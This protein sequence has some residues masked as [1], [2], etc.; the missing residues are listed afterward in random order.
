[1]KYLFCF[2]LSF[3]LFAQ[4]RENVAR[5]LS[6][7]KAPEYVFKACAFTDLSWRLAFE[8]IAETRNL[9]D[10]NCVLTAMDQYE[11]TK[12]QREAVET[13]RKNAR[14]YLQ[15]FNCETLAGFQKAICLQ[16]K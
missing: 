2:L 16:F 5:N 13:E 3:N 10:Y 15:N 6:L 7:V 8:R 14:E 9:T 1:M 4:T 12:A 11:T